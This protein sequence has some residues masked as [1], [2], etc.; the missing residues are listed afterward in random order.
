[1]NISPT[2]RHQVAI[3][4]AGT[5]GLALAHG[6]RRAGIDV[7]VYE[8]DRTRRDGLQGYRVGISPDGS[9]AL[10][11]LLPPDLYA[12][13]VA[14]CARPPRSLTFLDERLRPLLEITERDG[15]EIGDDPVE[16]EKSVSRMTLRQVLLTGL[17]D[18]VHF[19]RTFTRY[20]VRPD[21]AVE[22]HFEDGTSVVADLLVGADG[23]NSRVR[24]QLLPHAELRDTGIVAVAGKAPL[25]DEVRELIT[26]PLWNGVALVF[27]P[28]GY[29]LVS[30]TME[31]EWGPDGPKAGI[32]RTE[33]EL[34][35]R[36]PGLLF[37]NTSDY[38]MWGFG[39]S[40]KR[41][42]VDLM[43]LH[44]RELIDQT[45]AL[46]PGWHPNLRR[47]FELSDPGATFP[48]S[49][50]TSVPVE[51]WPTGPVTLIGDAIHTM[52][53]GRG[54]GA[55]TALL[56]ALLL[57]HQLLEARDGRR[58]QREAVA[59]YERAMID[60]G[61]EAVR[62]SLKQMSSDEPVHHPLWGGPA[63]AGMKTAFRLF[64]AVPPMKRRMAQSETRLRDRR[65]HPA[66]AA[67]GA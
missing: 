47:I 35:E 60:Y 45:L 38:F 8:R 42:P 7:G 30:H 66:L 53:P 62:D 48:I 58:G 55:N 34:I 59:A 65:L 3:I 51:P 28:R 20:D 10:H 52:T 16:S 43:A 17:D 18:A 40:R 63:L 49:I 14:T 61:F 36:W 64:N 32:G 67:V 13:F 5:G 29:S 1:M 9:R 31:F 6:L 56:D 23:S 2:P 50:R 22:A 46:T 57:C 26:P 37:D 25:T 11:A 12:T 39:G 44:G 19:D 27:A 54:V 24:R 21:G 41:L 33:A 4:G 15:L